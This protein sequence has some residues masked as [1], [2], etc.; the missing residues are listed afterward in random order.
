MAKGRDPLLERFARVILRE[1]IE[2][3]A[4]Q[5][6][7]RTLSD[8]AKPPGPGEKSDYAPATRVTA[9]RA[10]VDFTSKFLG[11]VGDTA[12]GSE[13]LKELTAM[14][15]TAEKLGPDEA[16]AEAPSDD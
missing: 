9:S 2:T 1:L 15:E 4:L 12:A 10:I 16:G 14:E 5:H 13:L 7:L 8:V 6:A 3:N 11:D